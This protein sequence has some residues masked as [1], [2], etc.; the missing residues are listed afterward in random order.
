MALIQA[1]YHSD[2]Q[3]KLLMAHR[4]FQDNGEALCSIPLIRQGLVSLEQQ[5]QAVQ[6]LMTTLDFS[7]LCSRCAIKSGGGCCSVY[8]ADEND[9]VLLLINLLAGNLVS[10]Q[11][12]DDFE[13]Y[14]LGPQGC[15]LRFKPIFCLNYNCHAIKMHIDADI[16]SSYL[17]ASA[18][19][20]Q[21]QWQVE[22][23]ILT[24]LVQIPKKPV[25][26]P[27]LII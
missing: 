1:L 24:Y 10:I 27:I 9:A 6:E 20:L 4:L 13:C 7:P 3:T 22:T 26:E 23:L 14:L 21:K 25:P 2:F 17:S 18:Q 16:L 15:T 12:D 11:K 5:A 8:M 19:L